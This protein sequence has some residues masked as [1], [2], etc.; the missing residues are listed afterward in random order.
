MPQ[1]HQFES[2]S[3]EVQMPCGNGYTQFINLPYT[4]QHMFTPIRFII[5]ETQ[6]NNTLHSR[7]TC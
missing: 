7:Q 2:Q 3:I 4:M 5:N 6:N 1:W